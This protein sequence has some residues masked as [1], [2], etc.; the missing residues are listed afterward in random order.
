MLNGIKRIFRGKKLLQGIFEMIQR[1]SLSGMNIGTGAGFTTSG[2]KFVLRLVHEKLKSRGKNK[3]PII[4]DVGA[5]IGN[6]TLEANTIFN[7]I[8]RI[9]SFEPS[10]ATFDKLS[11]N[12]GGYTN[13]IGHQLAL[14]DTTGHITLYSNDTLSA[15][16]SVNKR[17]LDHYDISFEQSESVPMDTLDRFCIEH[18]INEIDFLKIDVEG[19]ELS[20][21]KGARK[22]LQSNAIEYIQ[23]EF[24][25]TNID[26]RTFFQDF[27][28]LLTE[29]Y[30][31]YR[32]LTDGLREIKS[33][34]ERCEIFLAS[35]FLAIRK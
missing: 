33:Y 19:H 5:N 15:L 32:I 9:H 31:I 26:S 12:F 34:D 21:L 7:G 14:S 35:N 17:K 2:E 1:M 30:I 11:E 18:N 6:Y 24:G 4:F 8:V 29:K 28:Y 25:G 23:F 10:K 3:L 27:F 16:A 20:V 13:L 22:L